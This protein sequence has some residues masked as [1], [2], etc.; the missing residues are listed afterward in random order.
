LVFGSV[1]APWLIFAQLYFGSLLPASITAKTQAY[2]QLPTSALTTLM[3]FVVSRVLVKDARVPL[4]TVGLGLFVLLTL[5][6]LGARAVLR[7]QSRA[8]PVALYPLL[9]IIGLAFGNPVIFPWYYPPL[10]VWLDTFVLLGLAAVVLGKR[11]STVRQVTWLVSVGLLVV[12]QWAGVANRLQPL[13]ITLRQRENVYQQAAAVLR[14]EIL[15]GQ[16]VALPEIG[17]FGDA[18]DQATIIDTVGLVSPEAVPYLAK[19]GAPGQTFNYAISNEVIRALKP[20][21]LITLEIFARPTLL[22]SPEFL[23]TYQLIRTFETS[24]FGSKGLLVFK[25]NP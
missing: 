22:Q 17:V 23:Q 19:Q 12:I 21:Y 6:L 16:R 18:F 24:D 11:N 13:P 10:L 15:A 25:R 9:Y 1:L 7:F 2:I 4:V 8:W 5:Y 14:T 3:D 20:D